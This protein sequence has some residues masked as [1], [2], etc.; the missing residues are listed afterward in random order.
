MRVGLA[1][2]QDRIQ[3]LLD[4]G[5]VKLGFL[6][7]SGFDP[8]NCSIPA[9]RILLADVSITKLRLCRFQ[10]PL[11]PG[12]PGEIDETVPIPW[13]DQVVTGPVEMTGRD[14]F[15]EGHWQQTVGF[16][17]VRILCQIDLI[18]AAC[19]TDT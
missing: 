17:Q 19:D 14:V 7:E 18:R 6:E 9:G 3:P 1:S 10:V 16:D 4:V 15:G 2:V 8:I 12:I 13:I 11:H 5:D